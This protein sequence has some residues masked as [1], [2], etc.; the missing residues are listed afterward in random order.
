[1]ENVIKRRVEEKDKFFSD[2]VGKLLENERDDE[3]RSFYVWA[4][5]ELGQV[6]AVP[7]LHSTIFN[8]GMQTRAAACRAIGKLGDEES[9]KFLRE[10]LFDNDGPVRLGAIEALGVIGGKDAETSLTLIA[11]DD[12][13]P[14]V[15]R[16]AAKAALSGEKPKPEGKA[17][18]AT[19]DAAESSEEDI[20]EACAKRFSIVL[21]E[22]EIPNNTGNIARLCA[23]TDS[24]L[25]LVGKLGF[26]L[27]DA[28]LKRAGLDY[29]DKVKVFMHD[30]LDDLIAKLP[31]A[32]LHYFST[33]AGRKYT[34]V[35]FFYGDLLVFGK[36][37]AGLGDDFIE[38]NIEHVFRIPM[39]DEIRSLNLANSVSVGLYEALRQNKFKDF[40]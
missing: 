7:S 8:A 10:A 27:D 9:V 20:R 4:I 5:G 12:E 22:P 15:I 19:T 13:E 35:Q 16:E 33:K 39:K 1:M 37:T 34:D 23:A 11:E 36:E 2:L 38:E 31:G 26:S 17:A 28:A 21:I 6:K 18:E 14:G 29:W 40:R 3:I 24:V 32:R 25:H 30:S